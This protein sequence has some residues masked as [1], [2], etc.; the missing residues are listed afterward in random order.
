MRTVPS[1]SFS[2]V[3][4]VVT[5]GITLALAASLAACA[6][7]QRDESGGEGGTLRFGAAGAPKLFDPFYASDGET[8][9]VTRQ[10]MEGLV[11]FKPGTAEVEPELA[12]GWEHSPDGKT[13]T[14][15]LRE[16]VK[17]HDGTEPRL[18]PK[19]GRGRGRVRGSEC[20]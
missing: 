17:F 18:G 12:T 15:E 6:E 14:F 19:S 5:A 11:G 9:R 10:M 7:S 20:R 16:G 13:W 1:T 8:F 4:R 2:A 3:R